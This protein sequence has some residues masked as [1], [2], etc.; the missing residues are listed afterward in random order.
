MLSIQCAMVRNPLETN[1]ELASTPSLEA[2]RNPFA[3]RYGDMPAEE[4]RKALVASVT[5]PIID[6]VVFP[7]FPPAEM[8]E[9]IQAVP[10]T[11]LSAKRSTS[12]RH[13]RPARR[14]VV[15]RYPCP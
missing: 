8:Q 5:Q 12:T 1:P 9:R 7:G 10:T 2:G 15:G 14:A 13:Q 6:G 4:W 3:E 11:S